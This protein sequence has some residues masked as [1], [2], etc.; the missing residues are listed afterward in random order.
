MKQFTIGVIAGIALCYVVNHSYESGYNDGY[1]DGKKQAEPGK[2]NKNKKKGFFD[3]S[4]YKMYVSVERKD[5]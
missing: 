1:S 4:K 2:S 3:L 5:K